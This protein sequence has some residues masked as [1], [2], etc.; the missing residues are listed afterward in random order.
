MQS[1]DRVAYRKLLQVTSSLFPNKNVF[2]AG[3]CA[4]SPG[5]RS[6]ISVEADVA[7]ISKNVAA[8]LHGAPLKKHAPG[9]RAMVVPFGPAAGAGFAAM[10]PLGD[11]ALPQM[12]VPFVKGKDLFT[13]KFFERFI[14][15]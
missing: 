8:L 11:T 3:D 2:A 5:W 15:A 4:N 1:Q 7:S 10:G 14:T 9:P 6:Y 12:A 13:S